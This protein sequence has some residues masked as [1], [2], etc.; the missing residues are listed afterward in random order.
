MNPFDILGVSAD[1][2]ETELKRAYARG[3]KRARPDEHP[4]EFQALHEAYVAA[5]AMLDWQRPATDEIDD[6]LVVGAAQSATSSASTAQDQAD[7]P[8]QA[9]ASDSFDLPAFLDQLHAVLDDPETD[10][11][12]WLRQQ[13]ALYS[14]SLK[15][16]IT[17]GL[18]DDLLQRP[19]LPPDI[20]QSLFSFF[21]IGIVN[22]EFH[23]LAED[24]EELRE[25][26]LQTH[27]PWASLQFQGE[28]R[29]RISENAYDSVWPRIALWLLFSFMIFSRACSD[30]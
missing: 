17:P 30:R 29:P 7:P 12:A 10:V 11:D 16:A 26:S 8:P 2:S 19:P 27:Q 18:V 25:R 20:L 9:Q 14:L 13:T 5:L 21:G 23:W 6:P 22:R 24:V 3:I 1:A 28:N 15:R 4:Q